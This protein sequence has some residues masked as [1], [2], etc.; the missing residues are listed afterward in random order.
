MDLYGAETLSQIGAEFMFLLFRD[1]ETS[2]TSFSNEP[3]RCKYGTTPEYGSMT[4]FIGFEDYEFSAQQISQTFSLENGHH[5]LYMICE[6]RAGNLATPI[7]LGITV[8]TNLPIQILDL[9]PEDYTNEKNPKLSFQTYR[10]S[11]CKINVLD[12]FD[13]RVLDYN[14][15]KYQQGDAETTVKKMNNKFY[16]ETTISALSDEPMQLTELLDDEIY[17]FSIQCEPSD[18]DINPS[19][20]KELYF[21]TDFTLPNIDIITPAN[22]I[23][24]DDTYLPIEALTEPN[25]KYTFY[26]NDVPQTYSTKTDGE[27]NDFVILQEGNNNIKIGVYDKANNFAKQTLFIKYQNLG[28]EM[29]SISPLNNELLPPITEIKSKL[30][31]ESNNLNSE[32]NFFGWE[33]TQYIIPN[34]GT[35]QII[36]KESILTISDPSSLQDGK[37]RYYT[38]PI[39]D[40][41]RGEGKNILFE[42][43]EKVPEIWLSSPYNKLPYKG[44]VTNDKNIL[45]TGIIS[46]DTFLGTSS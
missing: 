36:G 30:F 19:E 42:I 7:S 39:A 10:N 18:P 44:F 41:Q 45:F 16:H 11:S 33:D 29:M 25:S 5:E 22:G 4:S 46:S 8:N 12:N 14:S 26:V 32:I 37:Y 20:I 13:A 40:E 43:G 35:T 3:V 28:P 15:H 21:T 23:T 6:D 9:K 1:H 34:L 24:V 2:M 27:I 17:G 38:V 31:S